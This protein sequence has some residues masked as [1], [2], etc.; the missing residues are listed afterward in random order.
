MIL[1]EIIMEVDPGT[2]QHLEDRSVRGMNQQL[3]MTRRDKTDGDRDIHTRQ[4]IQRKRERE[5]SI[6]RSVMS[7]M[8]SEEIVLRSVQ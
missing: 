1:S 2:F 7:W 6:K 8:S 5:R 4:H 3:M